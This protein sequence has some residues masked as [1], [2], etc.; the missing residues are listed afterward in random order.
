MAQANQLKSGGVALAGL[1][2]ELD[3][4]VLLPHFRGYLSVVESHAPHPLAESARQFALL[5][6]EPWISSRA[7]YW[8][9]AGRY[10]Q[11]VGGLAQFLPRALLPPYAESPAS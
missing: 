9:H 7:A 4:T 2:D 1:R 5:P 8:Q 10:D 3:L 6:P 11:Q